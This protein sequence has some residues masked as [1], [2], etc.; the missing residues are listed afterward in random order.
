MRQRKRLCAFAAIPFMTLALLAQTPDDA[1]AGAGSGEAVKVAAHFSRWTYPTEVTPG[2]GQQVHIVQKGDTL[3][4]LGNKYL[5]NPFA[6]PQIWE[7]NKWVKDPHWIYPGDPLL[8]DAS[9][10][11][12]PQSK[13]QTLAPGE[14]ADLQP[15]L[16]SGRRSG[17]DEYAFT[18]QDF[19]QMPYLVAAPAETYF[20]KAGAFRIVGQEDENKNMMADGDFIYLGGGTA[21]GVKAGDRFVLTTIVTRKLY[22]PEDRRRLTVLGDVVEQVGV[23]RVTRTYDAQSVAVI[24]RAL[25]GIT[26]DCFAM[27]FQEPA[28]IPNTLR[29]DIANPVQV[30]P[31][32]AKIIYIRQGRTVA[33]GGEMVKPNDPEPARRAHRNRK[34]NAEVLPGLRHERHRGPG[35]ARCPGWPQACASPRHVRHEGIRQRVE[36]GLQE[37]R[38][39]RR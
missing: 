39:H 36:P 12:V 37:V 8:V 16:K 13:D 10:G 28:N 33:G 34:G 6:W 38:P 29:T 17:N 27:R 20:K 30:K 1:A 5:G 22:H 15:D 9:R 4:D 18:F 24:E 2:P 19:L 14:V 32:V 26:R 31:P 21:Q 7:L 23:V 11:M 25:D 3:W 35:P